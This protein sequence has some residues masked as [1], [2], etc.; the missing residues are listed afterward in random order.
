[1]SDHDHALCQAV[2]NKAVDGLAGQ[3]FEKPYEEEIYGCC[4]Q[5][6]FRDDLRCAIG[7]II[8]DDVYKAYFEGNGIRVLVEERPQL[9]R[10]ILGDEPEEPAEVIA[11]DNRGAIV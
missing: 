9:L 4:Y 11:F 5:H 7:H 8:P 1:M 10:Y 6:P 3:S 2:Y